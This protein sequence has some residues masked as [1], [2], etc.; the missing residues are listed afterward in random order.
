[1]RL[2]CGPQRDELSGLPGAFS[3]AASPVISPVWGTRWALLQSDSATCCGGKT[4]VE[5]AL[6]RAGLHGA[7]FGLITCISPNLLQAVDSA[8]DG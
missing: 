8:W 3:F 4:S 7:G 1:M 2:V 6:G 5:A